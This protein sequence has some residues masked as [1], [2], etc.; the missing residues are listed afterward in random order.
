MVH[1]NEPFLT[2]W[3]TRAVPARLSSRQPPASS[4]A[5]AAR[6]ADSSAVGAA[7]EVRKAGF[8][9]ASRARITSVELR[10][11]ERAKEATAAFA[12]STNSGRLES[13]F[14]SS[15]AH[16]LSAYEESCSALKARNSV[17]TP[18]MPFRAE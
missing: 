14:S 13:E 18:V 4:R 6:A 7:S 8:P 12:R 5:I 3:A 17:A 10:T 2:A 11:I 15:A 1:P 16:W 9:S